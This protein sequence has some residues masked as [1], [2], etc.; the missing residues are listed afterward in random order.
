MRLI[1]KLHS[2]MD[3][4]RRS[5]EEIARNILKAGQ[6]V[7]QVVQW[8]GLPRETVQVLASQVRSE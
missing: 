4:M 3:E 1:E 7:E 2:E 5:R 8:T 6:P